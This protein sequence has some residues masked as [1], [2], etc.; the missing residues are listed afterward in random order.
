MISKKYLTIILSILLLI[1]AAV[2]A[3]SQ[4]FIGQD[5]KGVPFSVGPTTPPYVTPPTTPPPAN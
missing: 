5:S 1:A 4:I 2:L 3:V